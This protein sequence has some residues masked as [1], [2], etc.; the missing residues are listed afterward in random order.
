MILVTLLFSCARSTSNKRYKVEITTADYA[1][2][3]P[4]TI[5][6][7][8]ITF[9]LN[10]SKAIHVHEI[11]ISK[12]PN[13]IGYQDYTQ[14][15]EGSWEKILKELQDGQIERSG[16]LSREEALLPSWADGVKYIC[17]R[18]LVSPGRKASR[19]VF[20]EPGQYAMECWV[21]TQDGAIHISK[22]MTSP[23]TVTKDKAGSLEPRPPEKISV[24]ENRI[25]TAWKPAVGKHSF[26]LFLEKDSAG[27]PLHN[28]IHLIRLDPETDLAKVNK[29]LDWYH[30]GG[31]RSPAPA[32]FLGG[33]SIYTSK[34]GKH[35]GYFTVDITE[36]GQYAWIVQ[37]PEGKT[38]WKKFTL[39][40]VK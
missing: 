3:A 21:K 5:P 31:L 37:V 15:F 40:P 18:G 26:A 24:L 12:L 38:L 16:I 11:S 13:G 1:F 32:V 35:P 30:V 19:T 17:S 14:D 23:L 2:I 7:G 36:P 28:N 8:W 34:V 22:G 10:N 20:L 33:L 6:S 25:E 39:L 27:Y 9:V 4:D 29:W